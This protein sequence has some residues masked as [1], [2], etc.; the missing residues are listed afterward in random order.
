[1]KKHR[2]AVF[3][4]IAVGLIHFATLFACLG[5]VPNTSLGSTCGTL[6]P[7]LRFP[8]LLLIPLVGRGFGI[9]WAPFLT[10]ANAIAWSFMSFIA[11]RLWFAFREK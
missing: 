8:F 4:S 10:P 6:T 11:L 5:S 2:V 9:D 1:V 3:V 7:V